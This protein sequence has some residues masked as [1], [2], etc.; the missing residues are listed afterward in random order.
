MQD[1]VINM[2]LIKYKNK[3]GTFGKAIAAKGC[4]SNHDNYDPVGWWS[5]YGNH[6]PNLKKN[7]H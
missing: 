5:N 2:E 7:G 6:T 1:Q 3:E 4:E